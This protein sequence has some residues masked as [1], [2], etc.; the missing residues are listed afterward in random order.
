MRQTKRLYGLKKVS[1]SLL[2]HL[3]PCLKTSGFECCLADAF[4]FRL[5]T[6]GRVAMV[7]VVY[8]YA[9]FA[10]AL[11]ISCDTF[12]HRVG[13]LGTSQ[14]VGGARM[15]GGYHYSRKRAERA[16]T[17]PQKMVADTLVYMVITS[18]RV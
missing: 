18:S 3:T 2:A 4:V 5:I 13:A 7:A 14:E 8:V 1:R 15:Y 12:S 17:I 9:T 6:E 11:K 16:L 10:V